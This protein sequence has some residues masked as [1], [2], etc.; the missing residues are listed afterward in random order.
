M[1]QQQQES[2]KKRKRQALETKERIFSAAISLFEEKGFENI[3]IE[4]IA[5][6]AQVSMGLFYK[7]FANKADVLTEAYLSQVNQEYQ[8]IYD[9]YL[10][11]TRGFD[12]IMLFTRHIASMHVNDRRKCDLRCHYA[13][14]LMHTQRS[15]LVTSGKRVLN[16]VLQEGLAEARE[17]GLLPA[18]A[19]IRDAS[20][21]L[22]IILRGAVFEYL[23]HEDNDTAYDLTKDAQQL[24]S[25]YLNGMR[26][27]GA[28]AGPSDQNK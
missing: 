28:A 5:R 19:N 8:E 2:L 22:A 3:Q 26:A 13:N 10:L 25:V 20:A 1:D 18:G 9:R 27:G 11:H 17:D 23:L 7:Y 12:K 4:D 14:F 15:V 21:H 24:V 6:R 16:L